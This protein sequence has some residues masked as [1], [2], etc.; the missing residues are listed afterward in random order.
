MVLSLLTVNEKANVFAWVVSLEP[1]NAPYFLLLVCN[2]VRREVSAVMP[3]VNAKRGLPWT[4]A[5]SILQKFPGANRLSFSQQCEEAL[6]P[7][8]ANRGGLHTLALFNSGATDVSALAGCR[9]ERPARPS[10]AAS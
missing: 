10:G 4:Q 7:S 3:A 1:L 9:G 2:E 8:V 5:K 6:I